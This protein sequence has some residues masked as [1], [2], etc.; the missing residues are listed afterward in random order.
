MANYS[1]PE[2]ESYR[3]QFWQ[4]NNTYAFDLNDHDKPIY[5]I[6]TPP[7]TVSGNLHI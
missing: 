3:Q 2:R 4:E 6:D 5:S 1:I 7:P